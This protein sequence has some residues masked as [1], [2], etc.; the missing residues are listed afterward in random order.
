MTVTTRKHC[1]ECKKRLAG[2]NLYKLVCCKEECTYKVCM[3]C[4]NKVWDEQ[5]L[6]E[7]ERQ[8]DERCEDDYN[9]WDPDVG[10]WD[11]S[12]PKCGKEKLVHEKDEATEAIDSSEN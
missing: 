5:V 12:C 3:N 7:L 8:E 6:C 1:S 4:F 9:Y 10:P 11:V 2:C